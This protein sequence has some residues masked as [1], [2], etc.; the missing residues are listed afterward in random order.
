MW[1]N[2][3]PASCWIKAQWELSAATVDEKGNLA[4]GDPCNSDSWAWEYD[5]Q[6]EADRYPAQGEKGI[7]AYVQRRYRQL[8][9]FRF[10]NKIAFEGEELSES[11]NSSVS[12]LAS[13][14][15]GGGI[16]SLRNRKGC[17]DILKRDY[18]VD[19]PWKA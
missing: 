1:I 5:A 16:L 9:C 11:Q 15:G 3:L 18:H 10:T 8:E 19:L 2:Y 17:I 7:F 13:G 12:F 4:K 6:T 14:G